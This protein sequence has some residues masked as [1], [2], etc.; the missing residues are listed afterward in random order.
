MFILFFLLVE[1]NSSEFVLLKIVFFF[2]LFLKSRHVKPLLSSETLTKGYENAY[3][4]LKREFIFSFT[5]SKG[6]ETFTNEFPNGY[7]I[8]TVDGVGLISKFDQ[9]ISTNC[10]IPRFVRFN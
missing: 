10:E 3:I 8:R 6:I 1:K 9:S 7:A 2:I 5:F 4:S